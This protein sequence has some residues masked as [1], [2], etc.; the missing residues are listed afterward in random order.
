LTRKLLNT[1]T[2]NAGAEEKRRENNIAERVVFW[3]KVTGIGTFVGAVVAAGA[4]YIFLCQLRAMQTQLDEQKGEFHSDQR[5]F[6]G[7][8]ETEIRINK[9]LTFDQNE[10]SLD[11][12]MW[13]RNTG[14]SVAVSTA[15]IERKFT[16]GPYPIPQQGPSDRY[17]SDII[18]CNVILQRLS[19]T[20]ER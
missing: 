3:T 13:F 2:A 8:D 11:I 17:L 1:V 5:P 18:N 12:D 6:V 14:K 7:I 4:A 15:S 19:Q 9:P 10:A 20:W 16:I